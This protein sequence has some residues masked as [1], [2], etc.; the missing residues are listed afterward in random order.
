VALTE[1]QSPP[2]TPAVKRSFPDDTSSH[3]PTAKRRLY[4][5][6]PAADNRS[7][8]ASPSPGLAA[9]SIK[10][11]P[12]PRNPITLA[13]EEQADV[14]H[15]QNHP[16][17]GEAVEELW[18]DSN[19][20]PDEKE[21]EPKPKKTRKKPA[22]KK[23]DPTDDK[24]KKTAPTKKPRP[25]SKSPAIPEPTC[26][27]YLNSK[28]DVADEKYSSQALIPHFDDPKF[29]P[30]ELEPFAIGPHDSNRYF[31]PASIIRYLPD[32]QRDGIKFMCDAVI[33][34]GG[35]LLGKSCTW[36]LQASRTRCMWLT[37]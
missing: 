16:L 2:P 1:A 31:V 23:A 10:P 15:F 7:L 29:G 13:R 26:D 6:S 17:S 22:S 14:Q 8:D 33:E 11:R 34:Y 4:E 35:A 18:D 25:V 21:A 9:A 20:L 27:D 36:F 28:L 24:S 3:E 32:Y 5:A 12:S 37:H 30:F 19:W